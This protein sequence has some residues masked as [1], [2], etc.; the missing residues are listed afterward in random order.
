MTQQEVDEYLAREDRPKFC[1]RHPDRE[2]F[3]VWFSGPRPV[4]LCQQ[5]SMEMARQV[6]MEENMKTGHA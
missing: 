1:E 2:R 3:G 4:T 5:C 6:G